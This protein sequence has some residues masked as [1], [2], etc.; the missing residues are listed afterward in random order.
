M[1]DNF[2][3][4]VNKGLECNE[5]DSFENSL[6]RKCIK[7]INIS[8]R[9][10]G[11]LNFLPLPPLLLNWCA[12]YYSE[13]RR[14]HNRFISSQILMSAD[15]RYLKSILY[16][17]TNFSR[18]ENSYN[19]LFAVHRGYFIR[20]LLTGESSSGMNSILYNYLPVRYV[21]KDCF[22]LYYK[23]RSNYRDVEIE[24]FREFTKMNI[25]RIFYIFYYQYFCH[26]CFSVLIDFPIRDT[27]EN[28]RVIQLMPLYIDE[29]IFIQNN[30]T[31]IYPTL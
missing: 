16:P 30:P 14:S 26:E 13:D 6:Q 8:V 28:A 15:Y 18:Y 24:Q 29:T 9:I 20:E 10:K 25:T 27:L 4:A 23:N 17:R 11:K 12:H 31:Y 2:D 3:R 22:Y 5:E 7:I 19:N 1:G 21:C